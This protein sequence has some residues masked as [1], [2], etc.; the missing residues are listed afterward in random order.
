MKLLSP[1]EYQVLALTAQG[2]T[3]KMIGK[4]LGISPRTVEIYLARAKVR[5][6]ARNKAQA[7]ALY[8]G[9]TGDDHRGERVSADD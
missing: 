9:S 6:G 7:V 2:E 1:R 3:A 8:L 4:T 5:L